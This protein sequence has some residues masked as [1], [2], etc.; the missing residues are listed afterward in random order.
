MSDDPS[1]QAINHV[2]RV[3]ADSK[4]AIGVCRQQANEIVDSGRAQARRI[5]NRLDDRITAIHSRADQT[6]NLA[7]GEIQQEIESLTY[8]LELDQQTHER[9]QAAID[10]LLEEMTGEPP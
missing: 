9:L 3:E 1:V 4:D 8:T 5:I 6:I 2:L 10:I 7:L